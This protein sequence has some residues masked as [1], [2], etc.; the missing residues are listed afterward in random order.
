MK[1]A[2]LVSNDA[3]LTAVLQSAASQHDLLLLTAVT[4]AEA[5]GLLIIQQGGTLLCHADGAAS[6]PTRLPLPVR[7]GAVIDWLQQQQ[8]RVPAIELGTLGRLEPQARRLV[9]SNG[10]AMPL[11]EKEVAIISSLAVADTPL[12]REQLMTEVW[13]YSPEA[14]THTL[15][16]HLYRLRQKLETAGVGPL[17]LNN[18]AGYYLADT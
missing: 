18:E 14:D 11:T 1:R 4:S 7:V 3:A 5:T 2:A 10:V 6:A 9:L 12:P 16:T 8:R 13:G 15:E 17:I